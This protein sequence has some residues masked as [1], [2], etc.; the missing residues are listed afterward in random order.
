MT[1]VSVRVNDESPTLFGELTAV[2]EGRHLSELAP[3]MA[4]PAAV[5]AGVALSAV[6]FTAGVAVGARA[7]GGTQP[8]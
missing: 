1:H 6:V 5:A 4:T 7:V 3:A 8:S 2:D